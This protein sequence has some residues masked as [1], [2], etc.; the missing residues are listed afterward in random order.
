MYSD[1]EKWVT[2]RK[3]VEEK[4][5]ELRRAVEALS[6]NYSSFNQAIQ[7]SNEQTSSNLR[8]LFG[9][10]KSR[11]VTVS[12]RDIKN[13][14]SNL[15]S[16]DLM[17]LYSYLN[18]ILRCFYHHVDIA[19]DDIKRDGDILVDYRLR[20]CGDITD[21]GDLLFRRFLRNVRNFGKPNP[22]RPN[23]VCYP[24]DK[25][26]SKADVELCGPPDEEFG[27][28]VELNNEE[29][30]K[31]V[32]SLLIIDA[33][34]RYNRKN[35]ATEGLIQKKIGSSCARKIDFD[36]VKREFCV[37]SRSEHGFGVKNLVAPDSVDFYER[38]W[39]DDRKEF[40]GINEMGSPIEKDAD[41]NYY[42]LGEKLDDDTYFIP[43]DLLD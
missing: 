28:V 16:V 30:R 23:E 36:S 7:K 25:Y 18:D 42:A 9:W 29:Y 12:N 43:K 13:W 17:H 20:R 2:I 21:N 19:V 26:F 39:E 32:L 15:S 6:V 35:K 5:L 24:I 27:V 3:M 37:S 4:Y 11:F 8:E 1:Y 33:V 38:V 31:S 22:N 41:G 14:I 10:I 34:K 40:V